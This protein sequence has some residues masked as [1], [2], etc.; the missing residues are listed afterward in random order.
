MKR[1]LRWA[2]L[3]TG[4]IANRF[5]T[6]LNNIPERAEL[7]AI[8]SR[9][10]ESADEFGDRYG[11]P[12]RYTGYETVVTDPDID[13]VYIGTPGVF[14]RRDASL[15]LNAE[16]HVLCE[17]VLTINAR[18][19]QDLIN[20][21]REKHLFLMEAMWTRFFPIHVRIR[22]LLRENVLGELRGLI[23][24][25]IATVP[26]D[27]KNRFYDVSLGAG[28]LLDLG[29][30]G[31]AWAYSLFGPPEE[32]TG[33]ASFGETGADYQSACLLRFKGGQIATVTASMISHDVKDAV[34]YGTKGKIVVHDPWYKPTVLTL[35]REGEEAERNE[36]PLN[37]YNGYEYEALAVMDCIEA[38][39]TECEI[40]PLDE[41]LE[42]I[43]ILDGVRQ[44]W[45][46][47]YPNE[48]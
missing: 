32:V 5:A 41:S 44:Q 6:A 27:P 35:H 46:F 39:K 20:L 30:Y 11:I 21:A 9:N 8:G 12:K 34:V 19:A 40:V 42:V 16:K 13:I 22:E 1:R 2:I 15:C 47:R 26:A 36:Y 43:R 17:K 25:F 33:L 48:D 3:G 7:A 4:K 10:S 24:P 23:A 28:V 14:H 31:I 37:S 29:S 18:E 45:G 38:G